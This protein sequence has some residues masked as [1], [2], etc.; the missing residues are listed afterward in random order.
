MRNGKVK[1]MICILDRSGSMYGKERSTIRSY[2]AMIRNQKNLGGGT[3]ITTVLFSSQCEILYH[4]V[5]LESVKDMDEDTYYVFGNTALFDAIGQVFSKVERCIAGLGQEN[6]VVLI[7]TDGMENA[8][9]EYSGAQ[10]KQ[11]IE[12][13]QEQGWEILFFGTDMEIIH[14]AHKIG[15]NPNH[16]I[17]YE[18]SAEGISKS[19][20]TA[21]KMLSKMLGEKK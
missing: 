21:S 1:E 12:V 3:Y 16:T 7:I 9:N 20:Q 2:N 17:Q 18:N 19:Y 10:I 14:M 8:S 13:K 11:I 5:P 15:I 4:H 6:V